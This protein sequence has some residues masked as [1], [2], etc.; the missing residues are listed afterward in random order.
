MIDSASRALAELAPIGR[1]ADGGY[2]RLVWTP[3]ELEL[4]AWF[5]V[6]AEALG[7]RV[8]RDTA[9]NLWAWWGKELGGSAFVTGSHLDSVLGG[10]AFDGPLGVISALAAVARLRAAG[11]VPRRPIAVVAFSDEEGGRFG[12]ACA[13]SRLLTGALDAEHAL[14]LTDAEGMSQR[15]AMIAVGVD[16][17]CIGPDAGLLARIGEFVE[18]HI[19]QG[20]ALTE[21]EPG[22]PSVPG[23]AAA[24]EP[25]GIAT[26]IVAHGRWRFELEGRANHA[27]TTPM[28][29][30]VDPMP[31]L[32]AAII[33]ARDASL[34]HGTVATIGRVEVLPGAVNAIASHVRFW[35]DARGEQ[36][37][38]RRVVSF[39]EHAVGRTATPESW[40]DTTRFDRALGEAVRDTISRATGHLPPFLPCGAGHDAGVL[41][42]AGVPSA[43]VFVRNPT[44]ISHA[45]GEEANAPD[46]ELGVFALAAVMRERACEGE[47]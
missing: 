19:E 26:E 28:R 30:R 33:A 34:R 45:P 40:T 24:G 20:H 32:A 23:L 12:V 42:T 37:A 29:A 41:A 47:A 25:L 35:L 15:E 1:D 3:A 27:G 44:G 16:P 4:R 6:R 5:T 2:R 46:I 13:G 8:E 21:G 18:L 38:V 39:V 43:M 17:A 11:A 10:G 36:A 14:A 31:V 9:G 7:L 22:R